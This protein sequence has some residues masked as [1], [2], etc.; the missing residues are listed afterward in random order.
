MFTDIILAGHSKIKIPN[1][2]RTNGT[3]NIR[4]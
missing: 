3:I 2:K 1:G 4:A